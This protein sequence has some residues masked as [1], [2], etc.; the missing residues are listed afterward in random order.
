MKR[1][2]EAHIRNANIVDYEQFNNEYNASKSSI[3]GGI[4]RTQIPQKEV[5]LIDTLNEELIDEI[6]GQSVDIYKVNI[7]N[8]CIIVTCCLQLTRIRDPYR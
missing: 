5:N 1:W 7:E 6:V 3:N 2:T 4:D 8:T